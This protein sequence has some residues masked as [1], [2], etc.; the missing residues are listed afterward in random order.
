MKILFIFHTSTMTG[1]ASHSGLNLIEGL[2]KQGYELE[3]VCNTGGDL[4]DTLRDKGFRVHPVRHTWA[5]PMV[6]RSLKSILKFPLLLIHNKRIN[7]KAINSILT[8]SQ[9]IK[10]D[11]IH[12]NTS[13]CDVGWEVAKRIGVPH[14]THYRE[15][16]FKDCGAIMWHDRKIQKSDNQYSIC[17]GKD[18]AKFHKLENHVSNRTIYNGIMSCK[19]ASY[20]PNKEEYILFVGGLYKS[21]GIEDLLI[22]YSKLPDK[23]KKKHNLKVAGSAVDENYFESLT[24]LCETLNISDKVEWLGEQSDVNKYMQ[25]AKCLVVPSFNEAFGRIVAEAMF[26]GCLVIGRNTGGVKE[27]FDNGVETTNDE[28]GLRFSTRDELT[29][30]LITVCETSQT[31][32]TPM[33]KR[34]MKTVCDLYSNEQYVEKVSSFYNT[35]LNK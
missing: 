26:S 29:E 8:I 22:A 5:Y 9:S 27:Q 6:P 28:I 14:I 21:K 25:T 19:A 32:Y 11:I 4:K 33:I 23:I 13:V 1:G 12:S 30:Q 2:K 35:I 34:A 31:E 24:I 3:I 20:N 7:K 18:V 17:I 15:F 16:G 10:P